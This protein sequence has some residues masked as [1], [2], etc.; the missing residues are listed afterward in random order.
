MLGRTIPLCVYPG[1]RFASEEQHPTLLVLARMCLWTM[2]RE[3]PIGD[4]VRT[5]W[6][7]GLLVDLVLGNDLSRCLYVNGSFEPNEFAYLDRILIPGFV[8]IDIGANEGLYTIFAAPRV[9]PT[10][11]VIAVE[12]SP[13]EQIRL[14]HNIAINEIENVRIV[15]QAL[16]RQRGKAVLHVADSEHNGQNTLGGFAYQGV[17]AVESIEVELIDLDT[18]M[19]EQDVERLDVIK[20]DVEGAELEVLLGAKATLQ[21]FKP[22][23]FFEL[24]DGALRKQNTSAAEV[25]DFLKRHGYDF[26]TFDDATGLPEIATDEE[27]LSQNV[28]AI[29]RD[30]PRTAVGSQ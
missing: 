1:W 9:A 19:R 30:A 20:M 3:R 23:L 2:Y 13:R 10:G 16:G 4:P 5:N 22:I 27:R 26:L 14:E 15:R 24:F 6:Y 28:I 11:L 17:T 8:F 29:H 12:P 7:D 18:L 21:R 25:L